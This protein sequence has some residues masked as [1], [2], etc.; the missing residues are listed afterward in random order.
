MG[1]S[2]WLSITQTCWW[3]ACPTVYPGTLVPSGSWSREDEATAATGWRNRC[4][5]QGRS[6]G[7]AGPGFKTHYMGVFS[8]RLGKQKGVM[9]FADITHGVNDITLKTSLGLQEMG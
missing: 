6:R 3:D 9:K 8:G 7:T 4:Q 1:E 2:K 5:C